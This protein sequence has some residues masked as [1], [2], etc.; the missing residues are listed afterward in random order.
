MRIVTTTAAAAVLAL[1]AA[2]FG[3]CGSRD[4]ADASGSYCQ[5]LKTDKAYFLSLD[6]DQPDLTRLDQVFTRMHALAAAAPKEVAADWKTLDTAVTTVESALHD[7]GL[8]PDDL[9]ALQ[10]GQVPDG[11]DVDKLAGLGPK[12]KALSGSEVN[13][14]A[15]R[16]AA[17]AESAC[18]V[19]LTDS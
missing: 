19:T 18:G 7:A 1:A 3:A 6:S 8:K 10:E 14:A 5:Q 9:A 12:M 2:T 13:D 17:D 4:T 16:I 15:D 11:V